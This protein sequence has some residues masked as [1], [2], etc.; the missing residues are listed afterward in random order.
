MNIVVLS[1]LESAAGA[2]IAAGRLAE[3]FIHTGAKVT[4]IVGRQGSGE[5]PWITKVLT[6]RD[7]ETRLAKFIKGGFS[8]PFV[9]QILASV[10]NSRLRKMLQELQPDIINVHN[11][12]SNIVKWDISMI[13]ICSRYAPVVWTLHDMWSFTGRCAY[14]YDCRKFLSGCEA[15]CPTPTEYPVLEPGMISKAWMKRQRL[16]TQQTKLAA[17]CPSRWLAKEASSGFWKGHHVEVI[18]NGLPLDIYRPLNKNMARAELGIN[19]NGLVILTVAGNLMERLKG[20]EILVRTL[21]EI[22]NRPITLITMG[23]GQVSVSVTGIENYPLGFIVDEHTK[24]LAYNAADLLLHPAPVDNLPN[25]I[26]ESIACGTPCVG[27]D[28]G[29]VPDMV[30]PGLTGWLSQNESSQAL[31]NAIDNALSDIKRGI[32]LRPSC[33]SVAEKEY[34]IQIQATRY[35]ELFHSLQDAGIN[36]KL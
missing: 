20:G 25:V 23:R 21:A 19:P 9:R 1:D 6:A 27:Y 15:S 10:L 3:G 14:S 31:S 18:P 35:L 11:M 29:G 13:A 22:R 26:I 33:R 12:H 5:Y 8:N 36:Q 30:R 34:S 17:V 32:D 24:V 2:S 4:Q 16:F 7:V 28:I